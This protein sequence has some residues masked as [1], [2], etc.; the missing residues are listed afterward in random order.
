MKF[1]VIFRRKM[2]LP[3]F[4]I[5]IS[6]M[7]LKLFSLAVGVGRKLYRTFLLFI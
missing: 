1:L 4:G 7:H 2:A 6:T 5:T 3:S